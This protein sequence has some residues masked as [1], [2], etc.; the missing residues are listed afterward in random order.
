MDT[1]YFS[2]KALEKHDLSA[3]QPAHAARPP[4][5]LPVLEEL[6]AEAPILLELLGAWQGT[7]PAMQKHLAF[8]EISG[9]DHALSTL[10][11][12]FREVNAR[13]E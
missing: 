2:Q 6:A 12:C 11:V 3:I 9:V 10:I 1:A 13:S 8:E 5:K 4:V 7:L